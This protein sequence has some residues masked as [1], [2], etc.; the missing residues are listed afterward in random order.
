MKW[1]QIAII[2]LFAMSF[3]LNAAKHGQE[4]DGEYNVVSACFVIAIWASI[5]WAGGFWS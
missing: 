2:V 4:R 3:A 1:P 5:L